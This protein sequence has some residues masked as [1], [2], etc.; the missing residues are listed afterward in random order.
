MTQN[1]NPENK[2]FPLFDYQQRILDE[3]EKNKNIII[4]IPSKHY[5]AGKTLNSRSGN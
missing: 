2:R 5:M 1:F 3:I 4:T